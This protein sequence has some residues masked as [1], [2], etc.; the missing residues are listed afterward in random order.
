MEHGSDRAPTLQQGAR[1]LQERQLFCIELVQR[2]TDLID[3]LQRERGLGQLVLSTLGESYTA[4]LQEQFQLSREAET[5]LRLHLQLDPH[6][7]GGAAARLAPHGDQ[8]HEPGSA[9]ELELLRRRV[10]LLQCSRQEMFETYCRRIEGLLALAQSA[11]PA[12][13]DPGL[14]SEL[15]TLLHLMRGKKWPDQ[16][17]L[18]P[19]LAEVWFRSCSRR[20]NELREVERQLLQEMQQALAQQQARSLPGR[21]A[22]TPGPNRLTPGKVETVLRTAKAWLA[23]AS[24]GSAVQDGTPA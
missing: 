3:E 22:A 18:D 5:A 12:S 8:A 4:A 13:G 16:A 15:A 10:L 1:C 21:P 7:A 11:G 20:M 9:G 24:P 19:T 2:C 14:G 6:S 23:S 17:V